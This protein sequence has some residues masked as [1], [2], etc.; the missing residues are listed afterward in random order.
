MASDGYLRATVHRVVTPPAGTRPTVGRVLPRRAIRRRCA[1]PRPYRPELKAEARGVTRDPA[2]SAVPQGRPERPQEPAAL[3]S[4]RGP[5]PS[6]RPAGTAQ[7]RASQP[8]RLQLEETRH[9]ARTSRA[10]DA[11]PAWRQLA[12]R[13]G[14]RRRRGADL[15]DD[16]LPVPGHRRTPTGCS[17]WTRSATSTPA[18]RIRPRTPSR[19]ASLRSRAARPRWRCHRARRPRPI[20]CSTSPGPA[21]TSSR[22]P[23]SMAAPGRCSPRR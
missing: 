9:D 10:R 15:P 8:C 20:R 11:G 18:S 16:V 12:R 1:A 22:R 13:S 21:T 7:G 3:A 23:T 6:R 4:R 14:D 19:R 2:Q 5:A 17:R